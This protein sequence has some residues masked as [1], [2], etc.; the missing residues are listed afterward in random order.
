LYVMCQYLLLPS[1]VGANTNEVLD[2]SWVHL[3]AISSVTTPTGKSY[4][5]AIYAVTDS[6]RRWTFWTLLIW[7][8]F[9][10]LLT[11]LFVPETYAPVLLRQRA[12]KMRKETGDPRWHAPLEKMDRTI[13]QVSQIS[14]L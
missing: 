6:S 5:S 14:P 8:L 1:L 11:T 13:L 12:V 7:A 10:W 2:R 9:Q 4:C 3:L